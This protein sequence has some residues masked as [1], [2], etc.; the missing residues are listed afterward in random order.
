MNYEDA[1]DATISQAIARQEIEGHDSLWAD[2]VTDH[3]ERPTY[4]GAEILNWLGY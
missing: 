4:L 2:F 3:G 1:L